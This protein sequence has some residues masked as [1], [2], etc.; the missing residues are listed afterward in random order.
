MPCHYEI[1][2]DPKYLYIRHSGI[3]HLR[4]VLEML[5]AME[6][7]PDLDPGLPSFDDMS[8]V[9]HV[10]IALADVARLAQLVFGLYMRRAL[11]P[12]SAIWAPGD[13]AYA[14]ADRYC[15]VITSL[16]DVQVRAFRIEQEAGEYL[17]PALGGAA[18]RLH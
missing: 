7:D 13:S 14:V 5:D 17:A 4:D 1:R 3:L 10:E 8:E 6:T 16:T 11:P 2:T 15:R 9:D 12:R 18:L